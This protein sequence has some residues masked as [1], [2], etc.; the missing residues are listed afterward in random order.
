MFESVISNVE[1]TGYCKTKVRESSENSMLKNRVK[2]KVV[3]LDVL[4]F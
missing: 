2:I 3:N 4:V 1:S